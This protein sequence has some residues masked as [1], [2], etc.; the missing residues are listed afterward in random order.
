MLVRKADSNV[1][2]NVLI[3][4]PIDAKSSIPAQIQSN[5]RNPIVDVPKD[6]NLVVSR[7]SIPA[8]TI[9]LFIFRNDVANPDPDTGIYTLGFEYQGERTPPIPLQ[10]LPQSFGN[11]KDPNYYYNFSYQNLADMVTNALRT[12][13]IYVQSNFAWPSF[14][15]Y[16]TYTVNTGYFNLLGTTSMASSN[17]RDDTNNIRIWFNTPLARCFQGFKSFS[18]AVNSP[19]GQDEMIL[20]ANYL[21]NY[22]NTQ[23]GFN[24]NIPNG[25][26]QIPFEFNSDANL[27]TLSRIIITS[28]GLGGVTSQAEV[29]SGLQGGTYAN[30]L[31]DLVPSA[32]PN[33][34]A[35]NKYQYYVQSEFYRRSMSSINPLTEIQLQFYWQADYGATPIQLMLSAGD[36]LNVQMIFEAKRN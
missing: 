18:N 14:D 25:F 21:N 5:L 36:S 32:T 7:F 20:I 30:V 19:S 9:P 1:Y 17:E 31:T 15:C 11:P 35:Y 6:Y 12:A 33:N 34:G 13:N 2:L 26:Y 24:P 16:M 3:N 10:W 27:Q 8:T 4:N 28:N 23:D 22:N 29:S